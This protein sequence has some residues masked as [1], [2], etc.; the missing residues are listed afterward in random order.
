M[1]T[2]FRWFLIAA[3]AGEIYNVPGPDERTNRDVTDA[4]LRQ[5][6]KPWSLV[7]SV[8]DR[9]G[10][11]RRYAMDGS[12][13]AALGWTPRVGFDE[14]MKRTVAWYVAN[15]PWWRTARDA[16]WADYYGRQYG[17]RL[18]KSVEA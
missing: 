10:H 17:W 16:D 3:Q 9:P 11:D 4:I 6:D 5:L 8:P 18:E 13:I 2:P 14:G 7:R 1:P 15:E 12:K